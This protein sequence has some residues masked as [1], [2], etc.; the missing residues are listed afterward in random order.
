MDWLSFAQTAI[1]FGVAGWCLGRGW[2]PAARREAIMRR[3]I[4]SE[5]RR[6]PDDPGSRA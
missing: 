6:Q 5:R 1:G 4:A 3:N 2:T